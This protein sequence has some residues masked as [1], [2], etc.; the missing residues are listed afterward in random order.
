VRIQRPVKG[1]DIKLT[2]DADLQVEAE[3][4]LAG[5]AGAVVAMK[6]DTG[7][8][9]AIASAPSFDP[10][11]FVRGID[12]KNWEKLIKDP[13]KPLL[14]RA[15]QSRYPPGSTFKII[16]ALAALEEGLVTK[17]TSY[18]CNGSIYFGRVFRCWKKE[19]HGRVH[20]HEALVE[21]CDVYFYEVAKRLD[22]DTLAQYAFDFG[23]GS[24]T[25]IDLE[26][27]IRGIVPGTWWKLKNK[28][29]K[30]YKGETL[31]TVIGQGYLSVT[32]IQMARLTSAMVNGGKLYRPYFLVDPGREIETENVAKVNPENIE[33]IKRALMNVV[34]GRKGTGRLAQSSVVDIG[35]K[36][37]TTQVVGGVSDYREMKNIPEKFRDH[38]WFVAFAP[39]NE[40]EI[41]VSVFVEHGGHGSTGAA[42]IAKKIIEKYYKNINKEEGSDV[43]GK[44]L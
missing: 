43:M 10:N 3:K 22:I 41:V 30:W 2:I 28:N 18:Y 7:E 11:L 13:K 25:G 44:S 23:L 19:G 21:S 5:R 4:S 1:T 39:E 12:Y 29:E 8:L 35:G 38:A 9:L 6:P 14:N 16:T 17:R 33:L 34:S 24:E 15:I 27:E 37:G 20:L 36:T 32:P 42:P 26:G 31:N 40:P